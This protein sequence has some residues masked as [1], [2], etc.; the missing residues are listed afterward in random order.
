MR[1]SSILHVLHL[2]DLAFFG[3]AHLQTLHLIER[4]PHE[5]YRLGTLVLA[6]LEAGSLADV[7]CQHGVPVILRREV[8]RLTDFEGMRST[9]SLLRQQAPD[10]LHIQNGNFR[11][12]PY[13]PLMA[14]L[15]GV[16]SILVTEHSDYPQHPS[17]LGRIRK[18]L[19]SHNTNMT[20]AVSAAVQNVLLAQYRYPRRQVRVIRN[21]VDVG[22]I[23]ERV[24][25]IDK[26]A[27]RKFLGLTSDVMVI[28]VVANL[29]PEKGVTYLVEAM[30]TI[31][32][33]VP[34]ARLVLVGD[35]EKRSE[36][37][38]LIHQLDLTDYVVLAGWQADVVPF[39]AAMDV[40]VLP[41]LF[42]GLGLSMLEAMAAGRPIVASGVGGILEVIT[43][44]QTGILVPPA[45]VAA[46]SEAII[47]VLN[48]REL[49]KTLGQNARATALAE[50]G[51]DA[52]VQ[53]YLDIYAELG[54]K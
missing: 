39:L 29:R 12:S 45:D 27:V 35:G 3:G 20:V 52:M 46:L 32:Q 21:G 7:L 14:R 54:V 13:L 6:D 33:S 5:R 37:E 48:N 19:I 9:V 47:Q 2:S 4:T 26:G 8:R 22:T 24:V 25:E 36:I 17:L 18:W 1:Q 16:R 44:H 53:A 40:F 15:A 51:L 42:E 30:P 10:I 43:D 38:A 50:Y 41:S 31:L 34:Q 11:S 28:G 23:A 49:A